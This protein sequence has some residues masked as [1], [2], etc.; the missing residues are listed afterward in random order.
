MK[1]TFIRKIDR[2]SPMPVYQQIV[3]DIIARVYQEEWVAGEKLPSEKQLSDE[4][5][6]SRVTIR[7][8]LAK[9][10]VEGLI[11][12][13]RGR[14]T[15]LKNNPRLVVQELYLPQAGVR[16]HSD[17]TPINTRVSVI[18]NASAE[19][20]SY[21][22]IETD[23]KLI[24]LER[25]FLRKGKIVGINRAWF[26]FS[27]F[28]DMAEKPLVNNSISETLQSRYNVHFQSV[29]NY[30]ESVILSA[31]AASQ[32]N[33]V[34]P[35]PALKISS[36]FRLDDGTPVEYSVTTWYGRDTLFRVVISSD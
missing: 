16:H 5:G 18:H 8:A 1:P 13:Q 25:T 9:L 26:P 14:G 17:N 32:L 3:N 22:D 29:D 12:K 2:S 21:L 7:Q 6:A 11:D 28:P 35:C 20:Y 10:E 15:Y 27:Y 30:I 24:F 33:T 19:V 23:T 34:S 31:T 4:Y 36:I